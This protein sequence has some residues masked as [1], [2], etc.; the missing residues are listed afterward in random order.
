[1]KAGQFH[2]HFWVTCS[3]QSA[4][5]W[6]SGCCCTSRRTKT[7]V[8]LSSVTGNATPGRHSCYWPKPSSGFFLKM[9]T[10]SL[11]P[12]ISTS[13]LLTFGARQL[14]V[15]EGGCPVHRTVLNSIPGLNPPDAGSNPSPQVVTT[16]SVPRCCPKSKCPLGGAGSSSQLR[17][18]DLIHLEKAS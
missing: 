6:L 11:N 4:A 15:V 7:Y 10:A 2:R 9:S 1:M 16:D 18:I 5:S 17:T 14:F 3:Q 8:L 12:G 13:A